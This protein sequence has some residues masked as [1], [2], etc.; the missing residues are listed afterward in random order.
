LA[1]KQ[2]LVTAGGTKEPI[3]PV[4]YIGNLSSGK[5]G[6]AIALAAAARGAIVTLIGANI[7]VVQS[8]GLRFVPVTTAVDLEREIYAR[9]ANTDV[10][11]QAAAVSDFRVKSP[12]ITK[13][14]RSVLGDEISIEL[15]AN[16]DILAGA[17]AR[18]RNEGFNCKVV[19]FAAETAPDKTKLRELAVNKLMSKGCDIIVANDVTDG[20]VFESN[21]NDIMILAKDG[22]SSEI[23][24]SKSEVANAILDI[25]AK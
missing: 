16:P 3:D 17:V 11:I 9:L 14:K 6:T 10:L 13:I 20:K 25:I 22:S 18:I 12:S 4:R 23:S 2:V 21:E 1:G 7:P 5:Q 8:S 15:I 24:G 19:G